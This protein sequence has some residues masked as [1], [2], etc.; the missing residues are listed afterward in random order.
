MLQEKTVDATTL[1]L[2]KAL[3]LDKRLIDFF[4]VGGTSLSLQIGHRTSIDID[5][6]SQ[7][8]F[9]QNVA[10]V[11]LENEYKF[12]SD[13]IDKNTLKGQINNVKLDLITHAYPLV[14]ALNIFEDIRMASLEDIS[15]MKLN[16]IVG[17]G[18]RL[19][20]FVDVAFLSCYLPLTKMMEAYEYKYAS[21]NPAMILK[22]LSYHHDIDFDQPIQLVNAKYAWKPVEKRLKDMERSPSKIFS[23]LPV[24]SK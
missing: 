15:A 12:Q 6:F 3:M 24:V 23:T 20:D 11:H 8:S 17:N 1:E 7:A 22:A 10:L 21:R 2:L 18:T 19:K 13:F 5:L 16:A 14:K 9:D 4:L